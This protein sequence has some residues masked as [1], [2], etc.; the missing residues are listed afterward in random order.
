MIEIPM[1]TEKAITEHF[2]T[3]KTS[4]IGSMIILMFPE[5]LLMILENGFTLV[6]LI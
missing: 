2:M 5:Y 1:L 3:I 6:S 4:R